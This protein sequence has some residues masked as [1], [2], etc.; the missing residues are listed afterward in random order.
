MSMLMFPFPTLVAV[1][2]NL[3]SQLFLWRKLCKA[4]QAIVQLSTL[5]CPRSL[6]GLGV[7]LFPGICG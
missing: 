3:S 1:A 2:A 6:L 5:V 7:S 4:K